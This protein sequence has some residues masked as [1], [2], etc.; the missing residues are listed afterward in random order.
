MGTK[1]KKKQ[2]F[3]MSKKWLEKKIAMCVVGQKHEI[4]RIKGES[5]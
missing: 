1:F 2:F 5:Q 4:S 3:V